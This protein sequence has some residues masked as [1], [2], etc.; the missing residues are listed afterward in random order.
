MLVSGEANAFEANVPWQVMDGNG[1]V[2]KHGF[3]TAREGMQL[4]PY[5]F[6]VKLPPGTYTIRVAEDDPSG[7]EGGT[8]MA[9]TKRITVE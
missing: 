5:S 6:K 3:A 8:P 2:V 9:D 1:T 7:G 4:S